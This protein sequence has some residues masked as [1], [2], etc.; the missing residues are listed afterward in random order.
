MVNPVPKGHQT[1]EY[2]QPAGNP[3]FPLPPHPQQGFTKQF[4]R[5]RSASFTEHGR[6]SRSMAAITTRKSNFVPSLQYTFVRIHVTSA[7][8]GLRL[9]GFPSLTA[10][11]HVRRN[12]SSQALP[13]ARYRTFGPP[14]RAASIPDSPRSRGSFLSQWHGL[15]NDSYFEV[16]ET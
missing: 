9:V 4:T 8:T 15:P 5:T 1:S 16:Q 3:R 6:L 14:E 11:R 12:L 13:P 7:S 10:W 2:G